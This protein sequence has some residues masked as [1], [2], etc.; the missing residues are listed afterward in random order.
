MT[1]TPG[2]K[3]RAVEHGVDQATWSSKRR[4]Q[5]RKMIRRSL[6]QSRFIAVFEG[7]TRDV[8]LLSATIACISSFAFTAGDI[9]GPSDD[10][11]VWLAIV[12]VEIVIARGLARIGA[13]FGFSLWPPGGPHTQCHDAGDQKEGMG[14]RDLETHF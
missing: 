4:E 6:Q 2:E 13:V 7:R 12:L 8:G 5:F 11:T 1:L 3:Q 14:K 9:Q 10:S